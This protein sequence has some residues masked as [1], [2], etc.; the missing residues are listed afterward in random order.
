MT[1][2]LWSFA[3]ALA[4]L[5]AACIQAAAALAD[6]NGREAA[7]RSPAAEFVDSPNGL[8]L[9]PDCSQA[10]PSL[11][12]LWPPDHV[13]RAITITG[14]TDPDGDSLRIAITSVT[15][16]E[17]GDE[18]VDGGP[19]PD[20]ILGSGGVVHLRAEASI[21]G[22][23]RVYHIKF[24]ATDGR[25]GSCT[26]AV[27][28]CV[29]LSPGA[30]CSDDGEG[31]NSLL[32]CLGGVRDP[33]IPII[34]ECRCTGTV[35]VQV[36][37]GGLSTEQRTILVTESADSIPAGAPRD[38]CPA[39]SRI[40]IRWHG[41][42][43]SPIAYRYQLDELEPVE[44]GPEVTMVTYNSGIP[45]ESTTVAG[46]KTF[47]LEAVNLIPGAPE[48]TRRF[49][50][51]FHSDSW[52]AGPDPNI[53]G[54]WV[55]KPNGEKYTLLVNGTL[56]PGGLPGT[57][58]G[59]DSVEVL[60]VD[61]V[62]RRTFLEIYGDSIFLRQEFDTV[63]KGSWAVFHSGG[64]DTDSRYAVHVAK[65]SENLPGFP[66]GPVLTPGPANGSP[67]GFR[68][69]ITTYLT[70][71]G[72]LSG[73]AQ[74]GVYPF[75][76]PNSVF[77]LPRIAGYHPMLRAGKAYSVQRAED[78]DGARDNRIPIGDEHNVGENPNSPYRPLV[79][80]YFTDYPP[81]L[82][83]SDPTFRPRVTAVD[84]F[85]SHTW[86]LRLPADDP[87]P[88]TFGDPVGGPSASATFRLRFKVTGTDTTGGPL[89]FLDPAP[90]ESQQKYI[91]VTNVNLTVPAALASGPATLTVELC[92]CAFCEVNPGEGRCIT[93]DIPVHYVAPSIRASVAAAR[94][95]SP[96]RSVPMKESFVTSL[97]APHGGL[98][99]GDITIRF[100]LAAEGRADLD[101]YNVT[102]QRVR[103]LASG[104]F[105]AGR[106]ARVWDRRDEQGHEVS[107][108]IYFVRM[109]AAEAAW[110]RKFFV[111]R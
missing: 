11:A 26:G 46:T 1:P 15:Q 87:D 92:D 85:F 18:A 81:E 74:T 43:S 58:L 25:G 23:G 99:G 103:R 66:G 44:V 93:R 48:A 7:P 95:G 82:R 12:V 16:D 53:A 2:R 78:G 37:G 73:P 111:A 62:A 29:P 39:G 106:Q 40:D 45:P 35:F 52:N 107:P 70:P 6:P 98:D 84:T 41:E 67:V 24:V 97:A 108:G 65:G 30:P 104:W 91:N 56:P 32:P 96:M 80:V 60:P 50:L 8:N 57:L 36:P 63:H 71:D 28:V 101:L 72:P 77:H 94:P 47:R 10:A 9:P 109:R 22:T 59:P 89:V 14:V 79:M 68:S 110:T 64:F 19:C 102:G 55:T 61:R 83:T 4:F 105:P 76:D 13:Y 51:N 33:S 5:S 54:P 21:A 20:A 38:T 42:P 75:F 27:D 49:Q 100:E 88:Y 90:H 86:D 3:L 17:P 31:I 69:R 34:D